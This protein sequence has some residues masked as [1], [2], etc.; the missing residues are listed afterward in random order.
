MIRWSTNFRWRCLSMF[1]IMNYEQVNKC[2][3][4]GN[5]RLRAKIKQKQNRII[6]LHLT[7]LPDI[8]GI[9]YVQRLLIY[10]IINDFNNI[11]KLSFFQFRLLNENNLLLQV[12]LKVFFYS[13]DLSQ[14]IFHHIFEHESLEQTNI[15][16]EN[17]TLWIDILLMK[18]WNRW[19]EK[20]V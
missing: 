12:I 20:L 9:I 13:F 1:G 14:R 8:W 5:T 4:H 3:V 7:L 16:M 10:L 2:T 6:W 18:C 19:N 15:Q 17:A 11:C